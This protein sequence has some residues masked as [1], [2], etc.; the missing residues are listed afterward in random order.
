[1][2]QE[3]YLGLS[4]YIY[5]FFLQFLINLHFYFSAV[6]KAVSRRFNAMPIYAYIVSMNMSVVAPVASTDILGL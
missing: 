1:M 6:F 2:A 4:K 5:I 3:K